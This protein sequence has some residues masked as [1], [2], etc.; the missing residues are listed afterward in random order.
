MPKCKSCGE[1]VDKGY[2]LCE[3]CEDYEREVGREPDGPG[4]I[5][6]EQGNT[7]YDPWFEKQ[8]VE[9]TCS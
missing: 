9:R 6:D 3:E 7:V 2:K 5:Y 4:T 1:P 8:K